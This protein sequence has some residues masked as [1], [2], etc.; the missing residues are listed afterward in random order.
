[1]VKW[2]RSTIAFSASKTAT[3]SS[4]SKESSLHR[5]RCTKFS[6]PQVYRAVHGRRRVVSVDSPRHQARAYKCKIICDASRRIWRVAAPDLNILTL[7]LSTSA[8]LSLKS[9]TLRSYCKYFHLS[10]TILS[11]AMHLKKNRDFYRT[12]T[13]ISLDI[14]RDHDRIRAPR[15]S[16]VGSRSQSWL[17]IL[18]NPVKLPGGI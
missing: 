1:M 13:A 14:P 3:S 11:L 6:K 4:I 5:A 12:V 8:I 7:T 17:D 16:L 15:A 2:C 9:I 18:K 10:P